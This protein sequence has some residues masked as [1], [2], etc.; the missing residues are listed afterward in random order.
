MEIDYTIK[1][2]PTVYRGRRYRSRLEARWAAMFDQ[3]RWTHEYEPYDLSGWAP[4]FLISMPDD[5]QRVLVE[6]KPITECHEETM[7]RMWKACQAHKLMDDEEDEAQITAVLL[8]GIA[9][10]HAGGRFQF[11]DFGWFRSCSTVQKQIIPAKLAWLPDF[12][13]PGFKADITG[14]SDDGWFGLITGDAGIDRDIKP[15]PDHTM[16]LW[17]EATNAVQWRGRE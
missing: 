5:S 2:I 1:A 3:L 13:T 15:Y 4:D 7:E 8:L 16:S 9:P 10:R 6:I 14:V 12:H 17:S 11:V